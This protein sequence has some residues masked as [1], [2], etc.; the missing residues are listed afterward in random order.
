M[1]ATIRAREDTVYKFPALLENQGPGEIPWMVS[2]PKNI[3][4][5]V[6]PGIPMVSGGIREPP[7][8]ALLEVS[9]A[10][11]PSIIPVP[12]FS[13]CLEEFFSAV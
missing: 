10:I 12:N 3:A 7:I 11:I 8:T 5:T 1:F 4:V 13:G 2:P 6:F 9:E